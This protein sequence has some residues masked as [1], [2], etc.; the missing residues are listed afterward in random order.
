MIYQVVNILLPKNVRF[1]TSMLRLNLCDYINA[2]IA[3]KGRISVKG[4]NDAKKR[5]RK[6]TFK[7]NAPFRS[8]KTKI[9]NTLIDNAE[10]LD[11]VMPMY[12]LL[13]YSE[14]FSITSGSLWNYYRDE[15]NDSADKTDNNDNMINNNKTTTSKSFKYKTKIIGR[16][17]T[18][19]IY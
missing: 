2:Y 13:E 16:Q 9:N 1:K 17:Q 3:V 12:D 18:I 11:I 10:D 6:L 15:V 8:C 4:T 7:N 19:I 5:N 14:N